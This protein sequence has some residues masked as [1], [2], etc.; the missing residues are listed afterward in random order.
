[1]KTLLSLIASVGLVGL[2]NL[3]GCVGGIEEDGPPVQP[4][5]PPDG[6]GNNNG[7]NPAGGDLSEAKALYDSG[8]YGVV[9]A[10]CTA[11]ACHLENQLGGSVS[12][13]VAI[14]ATSGWQMATNYSAVVGIYDAAS[15]P[16]LTKIAP[17][18]HYGITYT[19]VEI[20][21][22]TAWLNKEIELRNG[23]PG[24]TDP[25]TG[26]E[27]LGAAAERVLQQ[28]AGCMNIDDFRVANFA[29]AWGNLGSGEGDCKVCHEN[30]GEGYIATDQETKFFQ[31]L[32]KNKWEFLM[33]FTPDLTEGAV[34]ATMRENRASFYGV[35]EGLDPHREHPRFN[36]G[37]NSQGIIALKQFTVLTAARVLAGG[38]APGNLQTH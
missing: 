24:G 11:G 16:V 23:Q 2:V 35:A 22:I 6:D 17:A 13:F 15:A 9:K 8:V 7:D 18:N 1:M 27:T 31:R 26:T 25:V 3:G 10:K 38:C 29:D 19:P 34:G 28:F 37:D 14:D 21:G 30:G 20:T 5:L 12:K 32:T 4:T 36:A 33:Y